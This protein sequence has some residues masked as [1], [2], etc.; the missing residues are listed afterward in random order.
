MKKKTIVN[1]LGALAG[2]DL[3][4]KR[5][6][7][8]L[9]VI[10]ISIA[11]TGCQT[12]EEF[13]SPPPGP[14]I[15][16]EAELFSLREVRLLDGPFKTACDLNVETLLRYDVD[17]LLAPF[18]KEAGLTPKGE[19]YSNWTGLDGHVGGHYLSALVISAA[20]TGDERINSRIDY[21]LDELEQCQIANGDGYIGGVPDGKDLWDR[22]KS[23]DISTLGS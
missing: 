20:A 3:V 23:N 10:M 16:T 9:E 7:T 4:S 13:P 15:E 12:S 19:L 21:M 8:F 17:R 11:L 18:L 1:S 22:I 14:G 6:Y 2:G 5:M